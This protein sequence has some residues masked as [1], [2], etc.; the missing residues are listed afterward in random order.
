MTEIRK[1]IFKFW[2]KNGTCIEKESLLDDCSKEEKEE[3]ISGI[4]KIIE[5]V[6]KAFKENLNGE[7]HIENFVIRYSELIAFDIIPIEETAD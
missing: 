3:I 1:L 5:V 7:L 2:F 6:R 4:P